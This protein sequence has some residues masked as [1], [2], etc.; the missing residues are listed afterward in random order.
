MREEN[1]MYLVKDGL[2]YC[3]VCGEPKEAY[4]P[5]G[6]F[7][8]MKKHSRQCA[9][10]R[11]AYEEEQRYF[12][13]KEH[14]EL[15]SRNTRICFEE[16]RMEEWTFENA[17]MSDAVMNK[18]KNYV[19]SW[20]KMKRNHIG[21]LLWEPVG[22]GKSYVSGCIANALL[23]QEVT[24]KMTNFNTIIDDIFPLAD[25]TEY[26]NALASYELL[27]IDD[28]GVERNSEYALG[29]VFSVIDRRIR[30]GRPLI[31][32]TNLPL[33]ELKNETMLEKKRIYD[34]ILEMCT[35]IYVGGTSKREKI[36]SMKMDKAKKMLEGAEW[37]MNEDV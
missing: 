28:L 23:K 25:K 32:T 22:T 6:G 35:P 9:C 1:T 37:W 15:V 24:V 17:D 8:G 18:A 4:F 2:K 7:M 19:E 21:L 27:I 5:A 3:K 11:K 30:S 29:I 10:D 34:R 20:N 14:R 31:V 13:E 36:A 33:K 16:S 26:I 12:K